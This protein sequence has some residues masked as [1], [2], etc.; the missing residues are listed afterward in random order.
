M[1]LFFKRRNTAAPAENPFEPTTSAAKEPPPARELPQIRLSAEQKDLLEQPVHPRVG[2]IMDEIYA[3]K[4][5][6]ERAV[7]SRQILNF[8]SADSGERHVVQD[9]DG[10]W[11][12]MP[13]PA[14]KEQR[15]LD[16]L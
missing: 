12:I 11:R 14:P 10:F 1:K 16:A 2:R 4:A 6:A 9:A 13:G 5:A 15:L 8:P 3:D 7:K